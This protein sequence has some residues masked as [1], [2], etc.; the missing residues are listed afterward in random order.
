[1][2]ELEQ[3][4]SKIEERNNYVEQEKAWETS[5]LRKVSIMLMTYIFAS[6]TLL[7][8]DFERPFVSSLIPTLGYFLSFQTL[9]FIKKW[10]IKNK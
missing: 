10:F 2:N 9:P 1:M 6:L 5:W 3:R 7:I 8:L 4:I